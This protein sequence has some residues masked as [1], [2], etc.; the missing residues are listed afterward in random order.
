MQITLMDVRLDEHRSPYAVYATANTEDETVL[1]ARN[2]LD[3]VA[4][5]NGVLHMKDFAEEHVFIIMMSVKMDVIAFS[6]VSRGTIN[7]TIVSMREILQRMLLSNAS[8]LIVG[9]NHPSGSV[10][11][12]LQEIDMIE[13]MLHAC[14]RMGMM[15][16]DYIIIGGD[17]YY[18]FS[19]GYKKA[20]K[21]KQEK[22]ENQNDSTYDR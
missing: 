13:T 5:L 16:C 21:E 12:T 7:E 18:S 20:Q 3:A 9:H 10:E 22:K 8:N 2:P 14:N 19:E 17:G 6:E 15:F 1:S 11:P 4:L